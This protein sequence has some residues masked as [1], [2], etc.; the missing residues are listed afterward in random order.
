MA[1][2]PRPRHSANATADTRKHVSALRHP[3]GYF[4]QMLCYLAISRSVVLGV[5]P[6]FVMVVH[7]S[8]DETLMA[9]WLKMRVSGVGGLG[10]AL[11]CWLDLFEVVELLKVIGH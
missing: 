1:A 4:L 8:G 5:A 10:S 6:V 9:G 3:G 2:I 7:K 11:F